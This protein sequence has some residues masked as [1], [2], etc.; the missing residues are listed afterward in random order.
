[1]INEAIVR[2]Q[3]THITAS[4]QGG[5]QRFVRVAMPTS[6]VGQCWLLLPVALVLLAGGCAA[7]VLLGLPAVQQYATE[8][9]F[10]SSECRVIAVHYAGNRSCEATSSSAFY[11]CVLV[12]ASYN[13]DGVMDVRDG[14]GNGNFSDSRVVDR[15]A[16]LYRAAADA[17][18]S[19]ITVD[20]DNKMTHNST[21]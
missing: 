19:R 7:L 3:R 11:P 5:L 16:V 12:V 2:R 8:R 1:L 6:R 14:V 10:R 18:E 17:E 15:A 4:D 9:H 20:V 13:E 21:V